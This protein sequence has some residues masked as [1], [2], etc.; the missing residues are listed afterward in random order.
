MYN[1]DAIFKKHKE[2]EADTMDDTTKTIYKNLKNN[3][4]YVFGRIDK[5]P[6]IQK[7]YF[8]DVEEFCDGVE[9]GIIKHHW[10]FFKTPREFTKEGDKLL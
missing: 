8:E 4:Y 2:I 10:D 5:L 1:P 6:P 7:K 3:L 9:A